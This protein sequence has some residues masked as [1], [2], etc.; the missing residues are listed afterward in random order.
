M[1]LRVAYILATSKGG[2]PHYTA[3]LAN[4]IAK[5]INDVTVIKPKTTTADNMF[6]ENVKVVN[7]FRPLNVST[8]YA[9]RLRGII[10]MLS[11]NNLIGFFLSYK[12]AS[13]LEEVNPDI[14]HITDSSPQALMLL[15]KFFK[16]R[17]VVITIHDS[18][19]P[20]FILTKSLP[21]LIYSTFV[22]ISN[23]LAL[24]L[25]RKADKV[26]THTQR[27]KKE[28]SE[29]WRVKPE[30]IVTIP[31][32][33]YRYF[34]RKFKSN[35]N[36]EAN[37][38][39]FFGHIRA[40]S[41]PLD[42]LVDAIP[43]IKKEIPNI[44]CIIAG[45][46]VIPERSYQIIEKNKPNFEVHNYFIPN[47]KVGEFF[48]RASLVVI[49]NKH[50]KGHSGVLTIAYSFGKPVV[51]TN[52]GEFPTLVRDTSCGLIVPPD[53]PKALAEA[54]IK[55]LK[56]ENLRKKMS[57]NALKMAGKL[58]WDNIAKMH[59]KVYEEVLDERKKRNKD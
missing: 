50:Q 5:Y 3:E 7:A 44:K 24:I 33:S 34:Q 57:K 53:N 35:V 6:S 21:L 23:I 39:L 18:S 36:E 37:C 38:I 54:I 28:L 11:I 2:I 56:D 29:E 12:N 58:S 41:K 17:P 43:I 48:S 52:V 31:H 32:G 19:K 14:V 8:T 25:L 16:K 45:S 49:T 27:N 4:A 30:N 42:P 20:I 40:L 15:Y 13:V 9:Y 22:S 26:I 47:E 59:I 10:R 51:T 1:D 46:G 55:L